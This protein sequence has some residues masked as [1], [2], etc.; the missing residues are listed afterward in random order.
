MPARHT[1]KK[2]KGRSPS[3]GVIDKKEVDWEAVKK[4]S[5]IQC[6]QAEICAFLEITN[7]TL[8]VASHEIFGCPPG[9]KL[10]EWREGGNCSLRRKQWN[11]ADTSAAVAIFLGKQYLNQDDDYNLNHN[12]SMVNVIHYGD[13]E[14]EKW[15]DKNAKDE[16]V[17]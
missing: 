13:S 9:E 6:T 3:C 11:L 1:P 15:K 16:T 4:L 12:G 8:R 7:E 2:S 14:P 5:Q 10:S 17:E